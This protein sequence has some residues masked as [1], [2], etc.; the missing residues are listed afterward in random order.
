[1]RKRMRMRQAFCLLLIG[2]ALLAGLSACGAAGDG[3]PLVYGRVTDA[4]A[5]RQRMSGAWGG[6][7]PDYYGGLAEED[8]ALAAVYVTCD[9]E[10]V[11]DEIARA[12][13]R[14]DICLRRAEN[15]LNELQALEESWYRES[16]AGGLPAGIVSVNVDESANRIAAEV[17]ASSGLTAEDVCALLGCRPGQ[18]LM[19]VKASGYSEKKGGAGE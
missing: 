10:T 4:D 11:R 2:A 1:M 8:G 12:A 17:L 19:I 18:L 7:W 3:G 15:S 6:S 13:G 16:A 5:L 14:G 9:P